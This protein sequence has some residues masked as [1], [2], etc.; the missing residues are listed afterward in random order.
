VEKKSIKVSIITATYNSEL[1]IES[2]VKSVLEQRYLNVE[3][4]IIDGQSED[5]TLNEIRRVNELYSRTDG[6]VLSEPDNGIYDAL[7]KGLRIATGDIIGF[8]HS[9]DFLSDSHVL[10]KIVD[11]FEKDDQLEGVFG[12][13]HYVD[14]ANDLKIIRKWKG[15]E[16]NS[17]LLSYGWMPAHPTLFLRREVYNKYGDFD[18]SFKISADYDFILRIFKISSLSA[19]YVPMVITKMRL[20]GASNVSIKNII[21]KSLEDYR[22][23]KMNGFRCPWLILLLKNIS[24]VPQFFK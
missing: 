5:N 3:H 24:K 18:L 19:K 20:G 16:F 11:E 13:L 8:V 2:C 9:D 6:V 22:A 23:L 4:I 15:R 12:D 7:N 14:K 1:T 10:S 17:C 21:N